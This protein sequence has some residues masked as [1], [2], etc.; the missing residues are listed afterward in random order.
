MTYTP[1]ASIFGPLSKEGKLKNQW[2]HGLEDKDAARGLAELRQVRQ[3]LA[4]NP[5]EFGHLWIPFID[6]FVD[7]VRAGSLTEQDVEALVEMGNALIKYP[8]VKVR[9]EDVWRRAVRAYDA[10]REEPRSLALLVYMY[11]APS[12]GRAMKAECAR[13]LGKR[14]AGGNEH[15]DIYIDHLRQVPEPSKES[16]IIRLLSDICRVDFDTDRAGLDRARE[17]AQR[18]VN[19]N[20]RVGNARLTLG[21]YALLVENSPGTAVDHFYAAILSDPGNRTA[22]IGLLTCLVRTGEY[23]RVEAMTGKAGKDQATS[24][25]VALSHALKWLNDPTSEGPAPCTAA[26]LSGY[27]IGKYAG[28]ALESTIGMLYLLEGE[29]KKASKILVPLAAKRPVNYQLCYYAAWSLALSGDNDAIAGYFND[30]SDREARWAI[31]CLMLDVSPDLID[32]AGLRSRLGQNPGPYSSVIAA[33][34]ALARGESP[35]MPE[36]TYDGESATPIS[37]E[38]LRTMI[39]HAIYRGDAASAGKWTSMPLFLR[40]PK[41][42]R[43]LWLGLNAITFGDP[44]EGR[45]LLEESA[46]RLGYP[47]AALVLATYLMEKGKAREAG[48]WLDKASSWGNSRKIELLRAYAGAGEDKAGIAPGKL[49]QLAL[50]GELKAFYALGNLHLH[51]ADLAED[52]GQVRLYRSRAAKAFQKAMAGQEGRL[53]QDDCRALALCSE[54]L[55]DPGNINGSY[56]GLWNEVKQLDPGLRRPWLVWGAF[57]AQL[58]YGMPAG[59]AES[60]EHAAGLPG[61]SGRLGDRELAAVASAVANACVKAYSAGDSNRLIMLLELFSSGNKRMIAWPYYRVAVAALARKGMGISAERQ[62]QNLS[63]LSYA[64]PGNACLAL[65]LAQVCLRDDRL[66]EAVS[67]LRNAKPEGVFEQRICASIAGLLKGDPEAEPPQY[68]E[69]S[70]IEI[71][72]ACYLLRAAASF[73]K[74]DSADG[75][76]LILEAMKLPAGDLDKLIDVSRVLPALCARSARDPLTLRMLTDT[77]RDI[78]S[79]EAN[80]SRGDIMALCAAAIGESDAACRLWDRELSERPGG[81]PG[82]DYAEFL[83]YLAVTAHNSGRY[84]EAA[85]KL[86]LAAAIGGRLD[87]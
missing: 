67:A 27:D 36:W 45:R 3:S 72:R 18:L 30:I 49:E 82:A 23:D 42:D 26:S 33:R 58:W 4:D 43:L 50:N 59:M 39:G 11:K 79:R 86:R 25:L 64:D 28:E 7:P 34:L 66:D 60:G 61:L 29:A 51:Q 22:S 32:N 84:R 65:I 46:G 77:I 10:R 57:I 56:G 24:G 14:K 8:A 12:A 53:V 55:S 15:I 83:C 2:A 47:R 20:I 68:P 70:G 9:P 35:V 19:N 31:I 44:S 73:C 80:G 52:A 54:F 62:R 16:D 75:Y 85:G 1:K 87:A 74:G 37:L 38:A 40:L 6:S 48:Q 13:D 17:V 41:A 76:K 63:M 71:V 81:M 5:A 78:S 21:L 69:G